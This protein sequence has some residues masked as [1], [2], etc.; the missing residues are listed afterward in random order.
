MINC[1]I[2]ELYPP[3]IP[4]HVIILTL[5]FTYNSTLPSFQDMYVYL[6]V[7]EYFHYQDNHD[8]LIWTE[9]MEYG[10]WEDGPSKD[11]SR[12]ETLNIPVPE[13][14]Q[15]NGTWFI[16][17]FVAK[18][19]HTIDSD[20]KHYT[21]QMIIYQSMCECSNHL[22]EHVS[23]VCG[24]ICEWVLHMMAQTHYVMNKMQ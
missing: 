9:K 15:Q 12:Q 1:G 4:Y 3:S 14:V 24:Y 20:N 8:D 11:G 5:L 10:N 2:K 6:T 19:G 22:L 17:V 16:H 7:N 23:H 21:P 18:E 13:A